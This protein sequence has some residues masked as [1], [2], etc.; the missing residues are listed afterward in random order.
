MFIKISQEIFVFRFEGPGGRVRPH[1][2][3][4]AI[5]IMNDAM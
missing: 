1:T 2:M 3:V 5:A 4:N